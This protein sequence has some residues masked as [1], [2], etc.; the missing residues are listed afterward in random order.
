MPWEPVEVMSLKRE[1]VELAS[2][3]GANLSELC[4]RYGIS[5][6]TG[7]KWRKRWR[8]GGRAELEERS[9]R[10]AHSPN[11]T[12]DGVEKAVLA[13]REDHPV[14]GG[15]KIRRRLLDLGHAE[16]PSASTITEILR[17]HG[18][19]GV[20]RAG[21]TR[22][23]WK[24]FE[25]PRPNDLWQMDFKG[26]FGIE[27]GQRCH[28]LTVLDDCSRFNVVLKACEDQRGETVQA[29]LTEAF[30]RYGLPAQ[31]LCDNARPWGA[32]ESP[33]GHTALGVWLLERG[34]EVIHGGPYHPQTQGKEER[35]HRTLKA[36]VISQRT[37]WRDLRHCDRA[38]R[39]WRE[40]YNHERPHEA[41]DDEVPAKIY[42][43][44]QRSLPSMIAAPESHYLAEDELRRVKSKGEITY[45][46]HFFYIGSAFIGKTVALR[47]IGEQ[48][49]EVYYCWKR[50]GR[51]D[52]EKATKEKYRYH[53]LQP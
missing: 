34:V 19:L 23:P 53:P 50:L 51:I 48:Q 3:E 11:Q 1:F 46:N 9:R 49:W 42:R 13:I 40:T 52:L 14:W 25:R 21:E 38:F 32:L 26:H 5:R 15:R 37:V 33:L 39:S 18:R 44:S 7:Y 22:G 36:E 16:V 12:S 29:S 8:E 45:R 47:Q 43:P 35:F 2:A 41:L 24:R 4:R 17:R 31:I 27:T 28:P 10:P 20:D 6:P 30:R